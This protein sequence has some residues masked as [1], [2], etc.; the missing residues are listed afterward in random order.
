MKIGLCKES[1]SNTGQDLHQYLQ[2]HQLPPITEHKKTLYGVGIQ[3]PDLR[4]SERGAGLSRLI[5]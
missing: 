2:N 3:G 4:Q 1:V 5:V